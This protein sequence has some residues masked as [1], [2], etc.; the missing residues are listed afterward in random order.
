MVTPSLSCSVRFLLEITCLYVYTRP[1]FFFSCGDSLLLDEDGGDG[2]EAVVLTDILG[3]EDAL[4]TMDFKVAGN[5]KGTYRLVW[6]G[7]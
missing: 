7:I 3:I 1:T 5:D 6:Y 4:G 2:D